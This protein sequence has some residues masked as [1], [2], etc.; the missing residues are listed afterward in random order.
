MLSRWDKAGGQNF[1]TTFDLAD[2]KSAAKRRAVEWRHTW[3]YDLP[4]LSANV[5]SAEFWR[6]IRER[7]ID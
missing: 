7:R 2:E 5:A 4:A 3:R 6:S 1:N